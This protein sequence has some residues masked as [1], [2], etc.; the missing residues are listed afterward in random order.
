LDSKKCMDRN[1]LFD[2]L[3]HEREWDFHKKRD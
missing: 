3:L 1:H 2:D